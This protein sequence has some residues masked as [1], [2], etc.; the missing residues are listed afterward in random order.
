VPWLLATQGRR[1][2]GIRHARCNAFPWSMR[3]CAERTGLRQRSFGERP[4]PRRRSVFSSMLITTTCQCTVLPPHH[5]CAVHWRPSDRERLIADDFN[6]S[7]GEIG[8][9]GK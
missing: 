6:H 2:R 1:I 5:G 7:T 8:Y 9:D 3:A 4:S